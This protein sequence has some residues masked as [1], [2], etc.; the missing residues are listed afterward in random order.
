M[1]R[2]DFHT[3][4]SYCD[5]KNTPREMVEAAYKMGFTDFGVSGHADYSNIEPG[6]GMN[7]EKLDRY[8]AELRE[9]KEEF[10][11]RMRVHIGIELDI[12]GPIQRADDYAI[13][14]VHSVEKNG[15][16]VCVDDTAERLQDGVE[17]LWKGDWYAMAADYFETVGRVYEATGCNFVGH[18]DLLTKFNENPDGSNRFFDPMDDRF[19]EPALA[20]MRKL[21][22]EGLPFEINTGA[23]SRGYRSLPYP[24]EF[25]LKELAAMGGCVLINSD[26]HATN[27]IG[28][29]FDKAEALAEACGVKI[30]R[31]IP[32][33]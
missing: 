24:S 28:Y 25:L 31:E 19:V 30:L 20:A 29:A 5:G 15:E 21:N 23:M 13:G 10:Q 22:A 9:L 11:G 12:H 7:A 18:F 32:R 3:H 26:S 17:R 8:L 6:F 4:T 1:I 33:R 14:S 27:T 16:Y 2:T